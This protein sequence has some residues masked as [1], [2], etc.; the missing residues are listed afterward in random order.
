MRDY[1]PSRQEQEKL[2]PKKKRVGRRSRKKNKYLNKI[3]IFFLSLFFLALFIFL[4]IYLLNQRLARRHQLIKNQSFLFVEQNRPQAL[5]LLLPAENK[6]Q[7]IDFKY[8]SQHW[9]PSDLNDADLPLNE[10]LFFSFW[11]TNFVDQVFYDQAHL[12]NQIEVDDLRQFLLVELKKRSAPAALTYLKRNDLNWDWQDL[13]GEE[14]LIDYLSFQQTLNSFS[15]SSATKVFACPIAVI[16]TSSESGLA[17]RFA[18]LLEKDGFSIIRRDNLDQDLTDSYLL[19]D[20]EMLACQ[21]L[22]ERFAQFLPDNEIIY[23]KEPA[24]QYR[25]GAV[26]FLGD[27]LANLNVFFTDFFHGHF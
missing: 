6:V 13:N 8:L 1:C 20:K 17:G 4:L 10:A 9:W 22:T 16:N 15:N 11:L 26:L 27:D 19:V 7:V 12:L 5:L 2:K 25:A 14:A 23:N 18:S 24:Q 21:T 3:A